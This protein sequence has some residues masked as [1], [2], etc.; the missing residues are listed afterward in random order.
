MISKL[1]IYPEN[2]EYKNYYK[3]KQLC[4]HCYYK[5]NKMDGKY[6]RYNEEG[7]IIYECFYKNGKKEGECKRY[8]ENENKKIYIHYF[9]KNGKIEGKCKYY[10]N[11][12][13]EYYSYHINNILIIDNFNFKIQFPL[14]KFR[15]ILKSRYRKPIYKLLDKFFIPDISNIVGSYLFTLSKYNETNKRILL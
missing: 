10:E 8:I 1:C 2:G 3:N 13:L 9:Y 12:I 5:N 14:L 6:K 4:E 15:D 7:E 11:E